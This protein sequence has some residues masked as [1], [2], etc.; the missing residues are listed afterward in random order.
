MMDVMFDIPSQ[1][2]VTRLQ[3]TG[4]MIDRGI[5]QYSSEDEEMQRK[6]A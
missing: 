1:E 5:E 3:V 6:R 2:G 4:E